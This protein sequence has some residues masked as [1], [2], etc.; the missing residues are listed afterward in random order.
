M[1]TND[2][3]SA[4]YLP[5]AYVMS[6]VRYYNGEFLKE[7]EFIDDQKYHIDR[8]QRHDRL[9][10]V[11]GVAEGLVVS[12]TNNGANVTIAAGTAVDGQGRQIL[13]PVAQ[14]L[15]VDS[16]WAASMVVEVAFFE[17][18][19]VPADQNSA[20]QSTTRF[21][22]TSS[23]VARSSTAAPTP[24]A[25]QLAVVTTNSPTTPR[26]AT[27]VNTSQRVYSGVRLPGPANSGGSAGTLRSRGDGYTGWAELG[28]S[29][30]V[31]GDAALSGNLNFGATRRQML[32]LWTTEY[33]I[34]VQNSTT[35]F[36]SF[37]NFA[38]HVGGV[39]S[40]TALD[41][42]L[43]G[44]T[45]MAITSSGVGINSNA[46][47]TG[48]TTHGTATTTAGSYTLGNGDV[49]ASGKMLVGTLTA[50]PASAPT[51]YVGGAAT[52]TSNLTL[53]G[54]SSSFA[55]S[56]TASITGSTT[57]GTATTTAGSY[58][59]GNGDVA[60][61]GKMLVG[62]LTGVPASAPT[63]YVGGAA[64]ITNN[65]V[66]GALTVG[67]T[68][69]SGLKLSKA[70]AQYVSLPTMA[71]TTFPI[72]GSG[73]SCFCW[74]YL[75]SIDQFARIFELS[76][77]TGQS[78]NICFNIANTAA[79]P[80]C[81][82]F[83]VYNGVNPQ[84]I[85]FSPNN[86]LVTGEW[87]HVGVTVDATGNFKIYKNGVVVS[88]GAGVSVNIVQRAT[89]YIGKSAY[90]AANPYLDAT[91][92]E[93]SFW[94]GVTPSVL[95]DINSVLTGNESGLVGYWK[96]TN[97]SGTSAPDSCANSPHIGN[98]T[99][100]GT[101]LPTVNSVPMPLRMTS[102]GGNVGVGGSLT[103]GGT[104]IV[105]GNAVLG[106]TRVC[107]DVN[108]ILF[109]SPQYT[110]FP[111]TASN[112]AEISN[113]TV[114]YHALMILG[115]RSLGGVRKV[116]VYDDL[117]VNGTT[118]LGNNLFANNYYLYLFGTASGIGYRS[119]Y[120]GVGVD[121]PVVFG[122]TGGALG[123]TSG[124]EKC[125]LRWDSAQFVCVPY[126]LGI[127]T[128]APEAPLHIRQNS[129]GTGSAIQL[130][131]LSHSEVFDIYIDSNNVVNFHFA[132]TGL[133]ATLDR[134]I[135]WGSTSDASLK[136]NV[137]P[138]RGML[139]KLMRLRPVSFDW[140]GSG[141]PG[142]GFIAQEVEPVLPLLVTES[143]RDGKPLKG[144]S[145]AT[146][147][148]VAIAAIQEM[149]SE[150]DARIEVLEDQIKALSTRA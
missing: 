109:S 10:H 70:Q 50:V 51:L 132:T 15:T 29:L 58:T 97:S 104:A 142:L 69:K 110:G 32:N 139:D 13:L 85:V 35:Y 92:A 64:T 108:P 102:A 72:S 91:I 2:S 19:D 141:T 133:A 117:T 63:L 88:S 136:E 68:T 52:I 125:A 43:D 147:G 14:T 100:S 71:A 12:I 26:S 137:A 89:N 23:V 76:S 146:F 124:G 41:A 119:S 60:A 30:N 61:S 83:Q 67:A 47:I 145:Y 96:L 56:G 11:A 53:S 65:V 112:R 140:K 38:W 1:P 5:A 118:S 111:E 48:S 116:Q 135:V 31:T 148:V 54:T 81:L 73:F 114:N 131:T 42:G 75:N 28:C 55:V 27:G 105:A 21:T 16:T 149:K 86:S 77:G 98:G 80:N 99:L 78:D 24:G 128:F 18:N 59:L 94:N 45:A 122:N 93:L 101:S 113:D 66:A 121:G 90:N 25:V 37:E 143:S 49:A 115:N 134:H 130:E 33:G 123:T 46:S 150:Y 127:N 22:Q 36:R 6:R 3:N 39:H 17:A 44:T 74:I 8:R 144:L 4:P 84:T 103:V 87:I 34:G 40:D 20:V 9:L 57:H 129:G 120:G 106:G 138:L 62:T 107:N 82:Q 95:T 126:R 7:G 79:N